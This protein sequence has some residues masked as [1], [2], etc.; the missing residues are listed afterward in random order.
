MFNEADGK[1]A[2]TSDVMKV[3]RCKKQVCSDRK[4]PRPRSWA[5]GKMKMLSG[6]QAD[7]TAVKRLS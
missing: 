3:M 2:H 6:S 4:N 7:P 1:Y 5:Q